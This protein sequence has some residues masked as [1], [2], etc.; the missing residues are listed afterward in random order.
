MPI[1]EYYCPV[2]DGRFRHLARRI[3]APPPACPRCGNGDV[4]RMISRVNINRGTTYHE[5]Q[6]QETSSQVD[7]DDPGAIAQFLQ[8]SG[9]LND[10]EGLYGSATY[11]ELIARRA[12][13]A[14]DEDLTD[15]T[16]DLVTQMQASEATTMAGA[17]MFSDRVENRMQAEGPPEDHDHVDSSTE[18]APHPRSAEDLGWG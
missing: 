7:S 6:F 18:R 10:A 8:E 16:D 11:R 13:G 17:V 5:R 1:Y 15:L 3:D 4:E 12:K 2:C 9:R 14:T